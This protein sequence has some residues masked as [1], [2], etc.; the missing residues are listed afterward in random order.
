MRA[1]ARIIT[2]RIEPTLPNKPAT[3]GAPRPTR[4][5][6]ITRPISQQTT[7]PRRIV[8]SEG[9]I[10]RLPPVMMLVEERWKKLKGLTMAPRIGTLLRK[11]GRKRL[12]VRDLP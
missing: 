3:T 10:R 2:T 12:S 7:V 9:R 11:L 5:R 4:G 1:I 6:E 8:T